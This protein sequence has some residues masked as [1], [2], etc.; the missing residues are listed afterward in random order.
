MTCIFPF[1]K[2]SLRPYIDLKTF[3]ML[4]GTVRANEPILNFVDVTDGDLDPANWNVS[5]WAS[6]AQAV[7]APLCYI[8]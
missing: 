7:L 5:G 4:C 2:F 8:I 6:E 3:Q 1:K